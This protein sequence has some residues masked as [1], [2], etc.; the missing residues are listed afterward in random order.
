MKKRFDDSDKANIVVG[1]NLLAKKESKASDR[2]W[3][4]D[5]QTT[6]L[7]GVSKSTSWIERDS[8]EGYGESEVS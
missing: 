4:F 2:M 1:V 7:W 5:A 6:I 8:N 3:R